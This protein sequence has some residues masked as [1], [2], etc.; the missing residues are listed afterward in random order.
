MMTLKLGRLAVAGAVVAFALCGLFV[1]A[2]HAPSPHSVPVGVVGSEP[3]RLP[4]GFDARHYG[5]EDAARADLLDDELRAV[6]IPDRSQLLV[7]S[8]GGPLAAQVARD[9][10]KP[11]SVADLAPLPEHDS[12]GLSAVFTAL[13][14]VAAG[15][16]FG[17]LLTIAGRAAPLPA[18]LAVLIAFGVLAGLTVAATVDPLVGALTGA[19][20]GVAAITALAAAAVGAATHALGRLAGPPGLALAGLL[21]VPLG[22]SAAGGALGADL[23][24]SFFGALS[25]ALPVGAAMTA[26]RRVVYFDGAPLTVPLLV[27]AAWALGALALIA[28]TD[29]A[30]R[31]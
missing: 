7:A 17:A 4:A 20:W 12:R 1:T 15:M 5:S 19:F 22:Q 14:A 25:D 23:V 13:G 16:A 2:F 29:R 10:F 26:L 21:F 8:A 18:R 6:L 24:P 27:L 28:V 11:A 30:R 3:A 9:A 31:R